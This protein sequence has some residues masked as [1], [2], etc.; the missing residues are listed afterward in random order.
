MNKL[1]DLE[2]ILPEYVE[3]IS[4]TNSE[5]NTNF[6]MLLSCDYIISLK[7]QIALTLTELLKYLEA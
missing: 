5:C 7:I 1:I 2:Y 3:Q 6:L 4:C